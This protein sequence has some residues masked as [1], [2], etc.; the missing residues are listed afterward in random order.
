MRRTEPVLTIRLLRALSLPNLRAHP[1]RTLV[2][3]VGVA[4]GVAAFVGIASI[5]RAVVASFANT[6]QTIAGDAE[7]EVD[8]AAGTLAEA[9]VG[10]AAAVPGV[11]TA[12]GL[13]EA[14]VPLAD[15]PVESLYL[16]GIDFLGSP[17]WSTQF[18]AR[19]LEIPD[20]LLFLSQPSSVVVTRAFAAR[21]GLGLG[22]PLRVTGPE[23]TR[24]LYVRGLLDD[25]A[26][27]RLFGGAL[28]IMD[29]PAAMHELGRDRLDRILIRLAPGADRAAVRDALAAALGPGAVV[30]AP[31]ARG[32]QAEKMLLS[33]RAMLAT[34]SF[35][36]LV[37]GAFI[38]YHTVAV[39]VGQRQ[40][41]FALANAVGLSRRVLR[42][43]C[44]V[45]TLGLAAAGI[46]LG[47]AL[48][49]RLAAAGAP[50]VGMTASEIW[51]RVDVAASGQALREAV[52]AAAMGLV[53]ALT[54]GGLA[55]R[56][57]FRLPTVEALRPAGMAAGDEPVRGWAALLGVGGIAAGVGLA[58]LPPGVSEG[59]WVAA[60]DAVDAAAIAGA[61]GLAPLLVQAAGRLARAL[62]ARVR[63]V[64][65]RLAAI[66]L[67]RAAVH[68]GATTA[69]IAGA[70]AIAS[71]LAIL[72]GSFENACLGWVE[73]HFAADLLVGRGDRLRLLAGPP[74]GP[75]VAAAV[76]GIDGVAGVEPFQVLRVDMEG[77]PVCLQG[78]AIAER[79]ARGGLP[80]VEGTL[81]GAAAELR[82]GTGALLSDNLAYR[83]GL[84][85]GDR[86]ALPSPEG[87]VSLRVAGTFV[88]FLGSLDLGAVAVADDL[89]RT[90][91]HD[92]A[93]SLLRVWLAPGADAR[94]VRRR[95]LER[96]G[97]GYFAL[98]GEDFVVA[99]R[100]LLDR[101]FR[102]T[103]L[104][105]VV[106]TCIGVIGIVNTQVASMLDRART[107]A[108]LHTIG[109]P[110]RAIAR[111]VLVQ[112]ALLGVAGG[113]LGTDVGIVLGTDAI[114][115]SLPVLTGW[116][117]PVRLPAAEL[118]AGGAAAALVSAAAGWVPARAATRIHL[119]TRSVD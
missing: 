28:A 33:L 20:Q 46:V 54:A 31:E 44:V 98:T 87:V 66:Q 113:L 39:A 38:V 58:F 88:D 34:A 55:I 8:P 12:A 105:I 83:L 116:R 13:L 104:L 35:L 50:L 37:V 24:T 59:V 5:N 85:V 99:I 80:M 36:G 92:A 63:S 117:L 26:A 47:L 91:W 22:D 25:V 71:A 19:A 53:S 84:H 62:T 75:G 119:G 115:W 96:L 18:P 86:I 45:E 107:N 23:G 65:L 82:A 76:R 48:G 40:R 102:T 112:C 90:R 32:E 74:F 89:L 61:A 43:V 68:G 70:L 3:I 6:L 49:R 95:V 79:L 9:T 101:F 56:A 110:V 1:A 78:L 2:T 67:P 111:G 29:L 106:A 14:F 114:W 109:I 64:P 15:D 21:R 97:G 100:T 7:L 17:V 103:W 108:T 11:D 69:T 41:Q 42:R 93:A 118:L 10:R 57:T 52:L 27:A 30:G 72:V 16:I 73:Q 60:I 77:R 4:L 81:E 51:F 94:D